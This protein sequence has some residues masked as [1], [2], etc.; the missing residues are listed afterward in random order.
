LLITVSRQLA[1]F[2]SE[3]AASLSRKLG[4]ELITR[5]GL[6]PRFLPDATA[7]ELHMLPESAKFYLQQRH[8][9]ETYIALLSRGLREFAVTGSA[10]LLGFGS[11][12]IFAGSDSALHVRVTAPMDVRAA[13]IKS[14]TGY[15]RR[16]R[17]IYL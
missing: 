6:L 12:L 16:K 4:A 5:D 13:R 15:R 11:A 8:G 14:A 2:G 9:G 7:H 17:R 1:S 10:V 3:I